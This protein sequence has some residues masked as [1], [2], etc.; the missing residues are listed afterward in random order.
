MIASL[1]L[2]VALSGTDAW[3]GLEPHAAVVNPVL[4]AIEPE[5][6]ISLS[7]TWDFRAEGFLNRRSAINVGSFCRGEDWVWSDTNR[8]RKLRVPGCWEAQGVGAPALSRPW[9]CR[10]DCSLRPLRHAHQGEGWYRRNVVVP[11]SWAGRRQWLK[12]G[13]VGNEGWFW[14]NGHPVADVLLYTGTVKYDVTDFLRPGETNVIVVQAINTGTSRLGNLNSENYWGGLLRSVELESTPADVWIDDAWVRGDF[15]RRMAEVRV[16]VGHVAERMPGRDGGDRP[17]AGLVLRATVE[18]DVAQVQLDHTNTQTHVLRVPLRAFRP[19]SPSAPNL[20]TA[21]VEL[22]S[23]DGRILQ[24]RQERFGVRKLEVRGREFY[25]ND[26]PFFVRGVGWHNI[27][28]LDGLVPA[29]REKLRPIAEKIRSAGFNVCRFHTSSRPP[30]LFEVADEVGLMLEPELPYYADIPASGQVFDPFRDADELYRNYRRHPS[31]AFYSGGNEGWFGPETSRRLYEEIRRRDPDRLMIGQDGWNN[32]Q[33]NLRGTTDFGGGPMTVWPRGTVDP[34]MPFVCHEYLN[35]SVKFDSR[36]ADRLTGV[37]LPPTSRK[38]REAWLAKFGLS[39]SQGDRLQDAQARMQRIWRKYGFESARLDPYCDGYS[40][41]SLVDACTPNNGA[42][43]GQ[44]L[45]D[46]LCGDKPCGDT[47]E[48]VAVYNSDVCLLMDVDRRRWGPGDGPPPKRKDD[49]D[50]WLT[51]FATNRVRTAGER[52]AAVF[53][54]AHYGERPLAE[55]PLSWSLVADGTVLSGGTLPV[56][57]QAVGGVREIAATNIVVPEVRQATAVRM[58]AC[59]AGV[60]NAWDWW[61]F[62]RRTPLEGKGVFVAEEF[63]PSL[64]PRF[65]GLAEGLQSATAV[66]APAASAAAAEARHRGLRLITIDGLAGETNIRLGWWWMGQQMGLA[67]ARCPE[68]RFLP[69]DGLVSPLLFRIVKT[70]AELPLPGFESRNALMCCEG[71]TACYSYVSRRVRADGAV[72][73][74]VNGLDLLADTPEGDAI[75]RGLLTPEGGCQ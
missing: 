75:L 50:L 25:L 47:A 63:R 26:R 54:L 49:F 29:D 23:A 56:A 13:V 38:D 27:F 5:H 30:E 17:D 60:T 58:E 48:S 21:K 51:D 70:G 3:A 44:A 39:L 9:V 73:Y 64:T 72:E 67:I 46:P 59:F 65:D 74:A 36:V 24:T 12:T 34:E 69:H 57:E 22:V 16:E 7:G 62:P 32:P 19:W 71:G 2:A 68:F 45:F 11:E 40:Y 37:W 6:L 14:V 4:P 10:W 52:I 33:T 28:P 61:I 35:L 18:G 53:S 15:D 20:Y 42:Y 41:W 66:I 31:F 55:G 1:L 43:T 8:V